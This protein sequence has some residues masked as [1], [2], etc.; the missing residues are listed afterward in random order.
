MRVKAAEVN[1]EDFGKGKK[2]NQASD[3]QQI[4]ILKVRH[5]VTKSDSD[6]RS[7]VGKF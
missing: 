4:E 5:K 7:T 1:G 6:F 3:F 2:K